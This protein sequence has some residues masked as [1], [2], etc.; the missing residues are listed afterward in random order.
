MRKILIILLSILTLA[1]HA[2]DAPQM[3]KDSR[4]AEKYFAQEEYEKAAVHYEKLYYSKDGVRYFY[5]RYFETLSKLEDYDGLE[6]MILKA[7]KQSKGDVKYLVD[8]GYIFHK[9]GDEKNGDK[10][11]Q[12]AIDKV[13]PQQFVIMSLARQ[14]INYSEHKFAEATYLQGRQILNDASL[15]NFELA[16][17]YVALSDYPKMIDAYMNELSIRPNRVKSVEVSLQRYLKEEQYDLLEVALLKRVQKEPDAIVYQE[18]LIWM[19]MNM[20]DFDSAFIQARSTDIRY[21]EDGRRVMNLARSAAQQDAFDVAID[22]YQY[23]ID[24]G[25]EQSNFVTANLEL[26]NVKRSKLI[27]TPYYTQEDLKSLE[28]SYLQF[29]INYQQEYT[30]DFAII[31]LASLEAFYLHDIDK[32]ISL[33]DELLQKPRLNKELEAKAKINLGDYYLLRGEH[34]ESALLYGQVEKAHRGSPI[35]EE[36]KLKNAKLSYYKGDFEW[37]KTQL[38]ILKSSTSELISND[39][40]DLSVFIADNLNLDT[41]D[42]PIMLFAKAELMVYQNKLDDAIYELD[43]ILKMYPFHSLTDD[44]Y[45]KKAEIAVKKQQY[46]EAT[47]WLIKIVSE[48]K[49]DLLADNALYLLAGIYKDYLKD[50]VKAKATYEQLILEHQGSTFIVDARKQFR[51]LRGD[52]LN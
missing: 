19:Y 5:K 25:P 7:Y 6:K 24:K 41:T 44:V 17:V 26:I 11:Y 3:S 21:K 48:H 2:Q 15:F 8:L 49:E 22:A 23:L 46:E 29:I 28:Q 9:K 1:I 33:L 10:Y 38:D 13:A 27:K 39:A 31:E 35:A 42:H 36:A 4:M 37:A 52:E 50:E 16:Y 51:K 40:I 32:A 34:W 47:E 45:Y 12:Q 18:M 14:F 20:D 43:G 30:T